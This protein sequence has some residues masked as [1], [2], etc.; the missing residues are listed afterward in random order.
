MTE[1]FKVCWV[2][3]WVEWTSSNGPR[4]PLMT[5]DDLS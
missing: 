3:Q 1:G 4:D 2:L 5:S